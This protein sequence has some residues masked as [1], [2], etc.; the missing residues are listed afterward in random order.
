MDYNDVDRNGSS[1]N[2]TC[3]FANFFG[4]LLAMQK[5]NVGILLESALTFI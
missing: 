2:A 5:R 3:D 1:M 4:M